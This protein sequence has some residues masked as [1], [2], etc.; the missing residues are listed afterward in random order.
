LAKASGKHVV[1]EQL[2]V[3]GDDVL[4]LGAVLGLLQPQGVDQDALV[5]N[6]CRNAL[7]FGQR[8]AAAG[9]LLEDGRRVEAPSVEWSL[10]AIEAKVFQGQPS[11]CGLPR[12]LHGWRDAPGSGRSGFRMKNVSQIRRYPA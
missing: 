2:V 4:D 1:L 7:E 5:G 3:R 9:Q 10:F 6:G 11:R 12:R 8:T